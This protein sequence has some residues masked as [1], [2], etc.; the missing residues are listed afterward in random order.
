M[1]LLQICTACWEHPSQQYQPV[2]QTEHCGDL[3]KIAKP[4]QLHP[5]QSKLLIHLQQSAVPFVCT[6]AGILLHIDQNL[7]TGFSLINPA[8]EQLLKYQKVTLAR[9]DLISKKLTSNFLFWFCTFGCFETKSAGV[10]Y[11]KLKIYY[12]D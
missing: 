2:T 9:L 8:Y 3:S 7:L 5:E 1:Y 11:K 4:A 10:Y 6:L 12:L